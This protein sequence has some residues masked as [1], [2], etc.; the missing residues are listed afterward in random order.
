MKLATILFALQLTILL[1]MAFYIPQELP[2]FVLTPVA[3]P[4]ISPLPTP[5]H[6]LYFPIAG[7]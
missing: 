1:C 6:C 2:S 7:E 3:E 4:T 5:F